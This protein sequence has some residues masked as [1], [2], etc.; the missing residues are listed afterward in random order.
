MNALTPYW[1]H[2]RAAGEANASHV[3]YD[4]TWHIV[5][6]ELLF[7]WMMYY[8]VASHWNQVQ[9]GTSEETLLSGTFWMLSDGTIFE[10]WCDWR[11]LQ[12]NLT[13]ATV[14]N[15][16]SCWKIYFI[17]NIHWHLLLPSLFVRRASLHKHR[18]FL[19]RSSTLFTSVFWTRHW[20]KISNHSTHLLRY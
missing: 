1:T 6:Q 13:R 17:T 7:S 10:V 4:R 2:S 14:S 20:G 19:V 18:Q 3:A 15:T 12:Y 5:L 9:Q 16:S 11:R 8:I